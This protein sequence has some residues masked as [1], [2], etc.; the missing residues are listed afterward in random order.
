MCCEQIVTGGAV[1][2]RCAHA[3]GILRLTLLGLVTRQT[4]V[5]ARMAAIMAVERTP[6]AGSVFDLRGASLLISREENMEL[7]TP[8]RTG[9]FLKV[10]VAFLVTEEQLDHVTQFCVKMSQSGHLRA[11]FLEQQEALVWL[12]RQSRLGAVRTSPARVRS[13]K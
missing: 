11:A 7:A 12:S 4:L 1:S 10:P 9:P 2:V 6:S 8:G 13:T 5:E 3:D